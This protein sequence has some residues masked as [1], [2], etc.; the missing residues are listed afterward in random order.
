VEP[1][2]AGTKLK[3]AIQRAGGFVASEILIYWRRKQRLGTA[4]ALPSSNR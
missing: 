3:Q 1:I 4:E 2:K